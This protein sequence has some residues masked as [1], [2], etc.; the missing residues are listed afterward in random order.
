MTRGE[1][2]A[3]ILKHITQRDWTS[4]NETN[5]DHVSL[6]QEQQLSSTGG[7]DTVYRECMNMRNCTMQTCI[8]LGISF[9]TTSV[10]LCFTYGTQENI[11]R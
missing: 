5:G 3:R 10:T 6:Q 2:R 9:L 7:K 1:H 8:Y 4:Q 11:A